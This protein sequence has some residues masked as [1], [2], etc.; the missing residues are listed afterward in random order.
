M[1][2]ITM[3][4]D[5]HKSVERLFKEFESAGDRAFVTKSKLVEGIIEE[6]SRH[7]VIEEQ[8]FYPATSSTVRGTE[9]RMRE[10]LEEHHIIKWELSELERTD[11]EDEQFDAKVAVLIENVRHHVR[12]EEDEYFPKVRDAWGR[13][14]LQDLAERMVEL[15]AQASPHPHPEAPSKPPLNVLTGA[16]A[17]TVDRV[18]DTVSGIGQGGVAAVADLVDRVRGVKPRRPSPTGSSTARGTAEELRAAAGERVDRA[19]DTVDEARRTGEQTT[20]TAVEAADD[21]VETAQQGAKRTAKAGRQS[22]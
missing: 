19:V 4:K 17:S 20:K 21:V 12:A 6:L 10:S 3:L 16:V 11:P 5:D 2:A 15:K 14:D 18:T 8:L 22:H 13:N 7:A 1:D 9:G